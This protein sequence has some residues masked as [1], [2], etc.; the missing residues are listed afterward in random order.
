MLEINTNVIN[1]TIVIRMEGDLN[2]ITINKVEKEIDYFIY[3][4]GMQYFIFDFNCIEDI[5][6]SSILWN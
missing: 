6:L 1:G 3:R 2:T 4:Q 5:D